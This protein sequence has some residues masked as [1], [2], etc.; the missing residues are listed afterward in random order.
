[1]L[2]VRARRL[3][4]SYADYERYLENP[5]PEVRREMTA[6]AT[7]R[8]AEAYAREAAAR[9]AAKEGSE[10][11]AACASPTSVIAAQ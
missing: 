6:Q 11:A 4:V 2:R 8:A 3:E 10:A 1:M 7:A 9:P 5:T